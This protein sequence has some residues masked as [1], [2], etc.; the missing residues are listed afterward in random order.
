[1]SASQLISLQPSLESTLLAMSARAKID[2]GSGGGSFL[3]LPTVTEAAPSIDDVTKMTPRPLA[4][5]DSVKRSKMVHWCAS[6]IMGV[7]GLLFF[8]NFARACYS[9]QT[10]IRYTKH[11]LFTYIIM[12][13]P[14]VC[15]L[16]YGIYGHNLHIRT[17][18]HLDFMRVHP[19]MMQP[20]T[21]TLSSTSAAMVCCIVSLG[22][23]MHVDVFVEK[24]INLFVS[25]FVSTF[26]SLSYR[27]R[28]Q[29]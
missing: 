7:V 23:N 17:T 1:M 26:I 15:G 24:R 6:K 3:V 21:A 28:C 16:S 19:D 12:Q 27:I 22:V 20:E 4:V 9:T 29:R 10:F 11:I 5:Y 18:H 8:H 25:E 13:Y 14:C 2:S